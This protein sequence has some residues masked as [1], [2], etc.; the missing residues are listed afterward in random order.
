[1]GEIRFSALVA[2]EQRP[3][4]SL[5]AAICNGGR[6]QSGSFKAL[7]FGGVRHEVGAFGFW[8]DEKGGADSRDAATARHR[9]GR[10]NLQQSDWF[11]E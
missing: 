4:E 6:R 8:R 11:Q 7:T 3:S 5:A 9:I 10:R 2:P 1:M